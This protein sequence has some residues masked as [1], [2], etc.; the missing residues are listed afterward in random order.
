[1]VLT[2]I[3]IWDEYVTYEMIMLPEPYLLY[4]ET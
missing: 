2:L 1:M 3:H 4:Y